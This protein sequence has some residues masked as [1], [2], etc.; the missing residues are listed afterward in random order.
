MRLPFLIASALALA[1]CTAQDAP[2]SGTAAAAGDRATHGA[3][4][5]ATRERSS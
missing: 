5:T 4:T 2:T 3:T 1:A